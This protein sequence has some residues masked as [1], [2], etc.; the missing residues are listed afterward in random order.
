MTGG[1]PWNDGAPAQLARRYYDATTW[2]Y[3]LAWGSSFHFAPLAPGESRRA[4]LVRYECGMARAIGLAAGEHCL[5]LGCGV[6]GPAR[7][8]AAATGATVVGVNQNLA[9]LGVLRRGSLRRTAVGVLPV[10]GDFAALPFASASVDR[11]YAFE[12]LCHAVDLTAALREVFRVLR[13]GGRLGLSE[14]S[15]LPGYDGGDAGHARL[16]ATIEASYGVVR[17]RRIDEWREALAAAGF[18]VP[19]LR[20]RGDDAVPG[21]PWFRALQPRD[22]SL[23][24]LARAPAARRLQQWALAAA[25][26]LRLAPAGTAA[27]VRQ[28]RAGTAALIEAGER[29]LFTPLLFVVAAKPADPA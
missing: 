28:L 9:Q 29:G 2:I 18:A 19:E 5:D 11:A 17:L 22:T 1:G 27:A 24:S 21:E 12:A 16:R 20:D 4:A 3:R 13:P 8:I 7:T 25:E 10:A 14:W 23:D 15:L 6:G 26:R